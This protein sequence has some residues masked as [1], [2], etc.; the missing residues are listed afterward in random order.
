M[1]LTMARCSLRKEIAALW[2]E[3]HFV[4][5]IHVYGKYIIIYITI[6]IIIYIYTH[7]RFY[8]YVWSK[9]LEPASLWEASCSNG[10]YLQYCCPFGPAQVLQLSHVHS[11]SICYVHLFIH[12]A[13]WPSIFSMDSFYSEGFPS[14]ETPVFDPKCSKFEHGSVTSSS[15]CTFQEAST[16]SLKH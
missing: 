7:T 15:M 4:Y 9:N 14:L 2:T 13:G 5:C 10:L 3:L 1:A 11:C 12:L 8:A 16:T 6:Y